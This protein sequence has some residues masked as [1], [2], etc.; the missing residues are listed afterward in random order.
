MK[1]K[2]AAI[3]TSVLILTTCSLPAAGYQIIQ[4]PYSIQ[5]PVVKQESVNIFGFIFKEPE[6]NIIPLERRIQDAE[7]EY[8]GRL[9]SDRVEELKAYIDKTWYVF[10]GSTPRGWDC[11][12]LTMWFYE[13]LG[14]A[15]EHSATKQSKLGE[16]AVVPRIGDLVVFKRNGS[17]NAYHVGIYVS[18]NI[19]IHAGGKKGDKTEYRSISGFAGNYSEVSYVRF[20]DSK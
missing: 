19:M 12:G 10:S 18:E 17:K 2:F 11:S 4:K 16:L 15:L 3:S 7:L 6:N 20:I 13:E 5:A 9:I 1:L 8:N 14:I